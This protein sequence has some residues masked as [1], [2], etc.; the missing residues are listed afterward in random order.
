[1]G[2]ITI[3]PERL[4][5]LVRSIFRAAGSNEREQRLVADH[6]VLANLS[7]H[8]SHGVG[9]IP[10]YIDAIR[11]GRAFV[12]QRIAIARD[13]GTIVSV[14][15]QRGM[16]QVMAFEAM[17]LGIERARAHGV[18]IIGLRNSHHIGR[19]GH[20]GEQA[21]AAGLIS[22]H[23][24]N[25]VGRFALVAPFGGRDP[26]FGTNPYCTAIPTASGEPIVLDFAASRI[27]V[28]KVRVA[29]NK[30]EPVMPGALIDAEGRPTRDPRVM[31]HSPLGALL[32]MGE[33]KGSGLALIAE[34]LAGAVTGGGT[35][36]TVPDTGVVINNML[37]I[38]FDPKRFGD[39]DYLAEVDRMV[40]W[41]K[42]SRPAA[43]VDRVRVAGEPER[44]RRARFDEEGIQIDSTTW[45]EILAA[46][47]SV[48]LSGDEMRAIATS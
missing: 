19:V 38:L 43:G 21:A 4:N 46:G 14:D 23:Y 24:A 5:A 28:G 25:V 15:G 20:Y 26:R 41:V 37:A 3:Q 36:A 44:E 7:G 31:F 22:I 33:H 10:T 13:T 34:L 11:A 29:M 47:Q 48:G 17:E 1:M 42:S 45:Y 8:D 30:G 32:P 16:G 18:A 40:A 39:H 35:K 27:A 2:Q 6:L 9:M 12:N